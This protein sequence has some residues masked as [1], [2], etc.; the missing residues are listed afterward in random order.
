MS[1]IVELVYSI[2]PCSIRQQLL[3]GKISQG[4]VNNSF[5]YD[6]NGMLKRLKTEHYSASGQD[7]FIY[8]M[9]F[10]ARNSG[11]FL[12]I[13]ANDPVKI[14][15]TY[16][17]EK[18]GWKGL[19]FEPITALAER[20]K[21]TRTTECVNIAIGDS[22]REVSF[23]ESEDS[24]Y[25]SVGDTSK[26]KPVVK[27]PQMR[28][29]TFLQ[30]RGI[31]KVDVAFIDVEGYEM[32]VLAGI[33]FEKTDITCFCIENNTEGTLKPSMELRNYL[34]NR[35]YRL[36]ARLTIDDVFIKNDYFK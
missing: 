36:V 5:I 14:N 16:L 1:K 21:T 18:H 23:A 4:A 28:L 6:D 35:G 10:D 30:E 17:L 27:V 31:S 26:G 8:H 11:F 9:V 20:W 15:N 13:G 24:V 34:I 7:I 19:A 29:T 12:D 25:S 32:N 22:E 33:D 2:L 3:R